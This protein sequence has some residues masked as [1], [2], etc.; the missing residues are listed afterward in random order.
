MKLDLSKVQFSHNDE[1]LGINVPK[2][3]TEDLAYFMGV[4]VGDGY[5]SIQKRKSA[6]DY[7]I[8][9]NGHAV[10]EKAWYKHFLKPLIK[11]L[12]NKNVP[13]CTSRV[14][15]VMIGFRSKAILTFL[16]STCGIQLSPKK[17]IDVPEIIKKSKNS[18]KAAFLRGLV[19]TDGSLVFKKK[20]KRPTVDIATGSISLFNSVQKLLDDLKIEYY[21]NTYHG[22]RK[23]THTTLYKVQ[24]NG[25]PRLRKWMKI[26]GF[27]S[28]NHLTKYMV[29]KLYGSIKP[30]T[31]IY[32][33]IKLI[34]KKASRAR[35]EFAN[36]VGFHIIAG[37]LSV[38]SRL[39]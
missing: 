7:R 4:H 12:F 28:Y 27:S 33:R 29:W 20:G 10:N 22:I 11:K 26:I 32:D 8:E 34:E 1:R 24:I 15:C 16:N 3:L 19:D 18:I 17:N 23:R 31:N 21:P 36:H 30:Y 38:N 25:K 9:Y 13:V 5:M 39:L 6:I 37:D 2:C 35:F 14:K